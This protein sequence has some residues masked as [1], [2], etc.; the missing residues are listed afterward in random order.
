MK[1]YNQNNI[2]TNIS[3]K[4]KIIDLLSG[5]KAKVIIGAAVFFGLALFL[6][7]GNS[8][9]NYSA[10]FGGK[11]SPKKQTAGMGFAGIA[12]IKK[13]DAAN[14][15]LIVYFR[16]GSNSMKELRF[17]EGTFAVGDQTQILINGE[18]VTFS[19]LQ[20]GDN[21]FIDGKKNFSSILGIEKI[22]IERR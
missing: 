18:Q 13:I 14:R 12:E 22:E 11:G 15:V 4:M 6:A 8:T 10:G 21:I 7:T 9:P 19:D 3:A 5:K 1:N 16:A 17:K 20:E 2:K